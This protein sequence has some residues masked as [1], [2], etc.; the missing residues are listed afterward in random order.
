MAAGGTIAQQPTGAS[1]LVAT[2]DFTLLAHAFGIEATAVEGFGT[3][4]ETT[5]TDYVRSPEPDVIVVKAA[6]TPPP[7]TS[8]RWYRRQEERP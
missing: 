4:F 5:L 6:M 7:S 1:A 2:P 8:P 3:P